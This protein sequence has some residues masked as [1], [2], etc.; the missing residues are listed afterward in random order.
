MVEC[1]NRKSSFDVKSI[2]YLLQ[3]KRKMR[4]SSLKIWNIW[5]LKSLART[6]NLLTASAF[7]LCSI[8]INS[9]VN[10][11]FIKICHVKSE[12]DLY[13]HFVAPFLDGK[14]Q[15]FNEDNGETWTGIEPHLDW[16]HSEPGDHFFC[17]VWWR[18]RRQKE[19]E[20]A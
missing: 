7:S 4:P 6:L 12:R 14:D 17:W 19:V 13:W 3:I 9:L 2:C 11:V 18:G 10:F 15:E 1:F 8:Q 20:M 16:I 5:A